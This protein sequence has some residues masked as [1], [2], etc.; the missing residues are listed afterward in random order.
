MLKTLNWK[1]SQLIKDVDGSQVNKDDAYTKYIVEIVDNV[2]IEPKMV[3]PSVEKKVQEN[4]NTE[5]TTGEYGDRYNDTADY[6]IG[7]MVPFKL[8]GTVPDMSQYSKYKYTFH[9]DLATSFDAPSKENIKVSVANTKAEAGSDITSSFE[10]NVNGNE[11]TVSTNN[12]KNITNVSEGKYIIVTYSAKLNSNASIGQI[13]PGNTNKV[14]LTYS[15]N[16]NQSG[17]GTPE[18]GKTSEDKVIVFTYKLNTKKIDGKTNKP[19]PGVTF[20]LYKGTSENK[21]WAKVTDGK[22][23]G[24]D[25]ENQATILTS[26]ADGY[27]YVAGL[28]A[29]TYY[30]HEVKELPGYNKIP[31]VEINIAANTSNGQNGVGSVSELTSISVKTKVNER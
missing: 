28:D 14:Y 8:I 21:Q 10:I 11:I 4:L 17:E 27:F 18:E 26:D 31:D 13:E 1:M 20:K 22:L 5:N 30:I 25:T 23:S 29:G 9:D 3:K 12:L 19:L 24:W 7:D 6:S 15:N 2:T 16:P